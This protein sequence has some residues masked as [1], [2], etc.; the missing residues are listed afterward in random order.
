MFGLSNSDWK[1]KEL[2][3]ITMQRQILLKVPI[4]YAF[5][6]VVPRYCSIHTSPS[7]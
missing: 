6:L 5:T 3:V 7:I 1:Y 4:I 2:R